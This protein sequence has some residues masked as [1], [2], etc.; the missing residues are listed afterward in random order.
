M[1]PLHQQARATELGEN[2]LYRD[3]KLTG[4]IWMKTLLAAKDLYDMKNSRLAPNGTMNSK[5]KRK[6]TLMT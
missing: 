6:P 5:T 4:L 3:R 1:K 2:G